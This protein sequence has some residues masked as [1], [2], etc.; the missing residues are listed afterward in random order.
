MNKIEERECPAPRTCDIEAGC[1]PNREDQT[2]CVHWWED[3]NGACCSCDAGRRPVRLIALTGHAGSGKNTVAQLLGHHRTV[4][5]VS[6]AGPLKQFCIMAFDFSDGQVYGPSEERNRPDPRYR[7]ADGEPLTPR[8]ALQTLGTEWGR[9]CYPDVWADLGVRNALTSL[10]ASPDDQSLAVIT[11]CR[12]VNE[13]K[14][15][16][17]AGGEVWRVHRPGSGLDGAAGRHE[18]ELEQDSP[19]MLRLIDATIF[20]DGTLDDLEREVA[21]HVVVRLGGAS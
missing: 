5:E 12:F 15:V 1:C 16:K 10:K 3:E 17:A 6:F 21:A 13:A 18:S 4:H 11:D 9:N 8:Y 7:R 2:H 14:A 19:E 20:N